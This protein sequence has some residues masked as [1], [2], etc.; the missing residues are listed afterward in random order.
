MDF[1][2]SAAVAHWNKTALRAVFIKRLDDHLK[3]EL[4][5]RDVPNDLPAF[6]RM[7]ASECLYCGQLGH[8]VINCSVQLK[9]G[10]ESRRWG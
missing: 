10:R 5:A 2:T 3:D 7:C 1:W 4:A 6:V 8:H 9:G